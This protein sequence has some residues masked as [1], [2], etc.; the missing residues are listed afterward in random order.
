MLVVMDEI[1]ELPAKAENKLRLRA[2][3]VFYS[4]AFAYE[5]DLTVR[6]AK[7]VI[8]S[9]GPIQDSDALTEWYRNHGRK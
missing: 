5:P 4:K 1:E 8:A 3:H 2:F 6:F 7:A 9:S